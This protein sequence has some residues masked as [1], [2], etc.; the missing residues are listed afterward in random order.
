MDILHN[1]SA[2]LELFNGEL[3]RVEE[4]RLEAD[5][6]DLASSGESLPLSKSTPMF[7]PMTTS[8]HARGLK[9]MTE[10]HAYDMSCEDLVLILWVSEVGYFALG[11]RR[12]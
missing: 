8:T 4:N 11:P 3:H 2:L 12:S 10:P 5:G 9:D 1:A 7:R 6:S